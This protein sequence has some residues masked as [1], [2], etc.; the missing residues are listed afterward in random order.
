MEAMDRIDTYPTHMFNEFGLRPGRPYPFGATT[1][2]GGVNFSVFSRHADYC[3]LVL[4][5][6]DAP[7]PFA[8]IPFRG[9][10][11]KPGTG[12]P[13]WGDFRIGNVFSMV[14]FDLNYEEIEYGFRMGSATSPKVERGQPGFHRF[15][16]H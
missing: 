6:K 1:V 10:F 8:E 16:P 3:V 11:T 15:D 13:F 14:V 5:M 7:Q 2:P 12:D 9:M 4:F